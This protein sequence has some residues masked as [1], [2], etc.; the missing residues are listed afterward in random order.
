M[1]V[2]IAGFGVEGR[3]NLEYWRSAGHEITVLDEKTVDNL[4]KGVNSLTGPEAFA[5]LSMYDLV[6]RTASLRPSRLTGARAITSATREFFDVCPA[7]IIGVTGT[8]GKGTTS[9]LIAS[10]LRMSGKTVHLVGN[11]GTAALE[12]LP[13]IAA[14]DI[15]VYEMSSFQLWDLQKSPHIAVVLMIEPDH[16]DIHMNF[17]EYVAAKANITLHQTPADT[18]VYYE[19]NEHSRYIGHASHGTQLPYP[20]GDTAYVQD[21]ALYY[22]GQEICSTT[23]LKL[24]GKHNLDNACAA[25]TATWD[26]VGGDVTVIQQGLEAF[27]GLPHR[28]KFVAEARGVK[29]YDDS[30]AT[31][32]GSAIAALKSFPEPKVIILG[33]SR[34]GVS[35]EPVVDACKAA[36]AT[37]V[38]IGQ[39]GEEITTLAEHA[40]IPVVREPGDMQAVVAA[41]AAV[42][43]PGGVVILSPASASFDQY[44]SYADRGE[45]FI[46][47]VNAL[48]SL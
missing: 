31:T 26:L 34:K 4:P 33:G 22:N 14:N 28:L 1:H 5:D 37:I 3:A 29:Y 27:E 38:A 30:I 2:A 39:T 18:A 17:D 36:Q 10:I 11:I 7:M 12:V 25:I 47:A 24:P 9:S 6:V 44:A 20:E 8:K 32:V 15:V 19:R 13:T 41:A 21:G 35:Y 46:A 16:L 43:V 48:N 45:Q 40:G 42:A 23:S